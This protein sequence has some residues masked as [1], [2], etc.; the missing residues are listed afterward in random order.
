MSKPEIFKIS[1]DGLDERLSNS[2]QFGVSMGWTFAAGHLFEKA[3]VYFASGQD[4]TAKLLRF[5]SQEFTQKADK[6]APPKSNG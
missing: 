2:H 1:E 5:L 6:D 4:D 3:K